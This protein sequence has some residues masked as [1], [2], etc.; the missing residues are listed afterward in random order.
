METKDI[1]IAPKWHKSKDEIWNEVFSNLDEEEVQ[2]KM[3][4]LSFWKYAAAAVITLVVASGSFAYFY[5]ITETAAR[6][7]HLAVTLPD[8]SSVN[9]NAESKLTYKP[10]LWFASRNAELEGEAYFEV[11]PSDRFTVK[12]DRNQVK[13]L[14]TSFNIFARPEKYSV[15]C[16]TGKVEV[17]ANGQQT[18]LT[19]DMQVSLQ[20]G[21]T[22][23]TEDV[24][25][26]QAIGWTQ[27]KFTF[28]G[29]PLAEVIKEVER[30]YDIKVVTNAKLDYLYTGN[31]SKTIAPEEAL[32]I[33][34]KP[35]GITFSIK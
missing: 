18:I 4:R 32:Q 14:G 3:K 25:A 27:N 2:P 5:A 24:D 34:G 9:L 12:S 26:E 11:K 35:F 15:T 22:E 30:Q 10:Y 21:Q 29:V 13:V 1:K 16:I 6:G 7:S 17:T 28:I 31:F 23:V 8:G 19:P 33:I 20:N